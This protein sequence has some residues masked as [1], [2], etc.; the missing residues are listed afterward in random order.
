VWMDTKGNGEFFSHL[1]HCAS[2]QAGERL[3]FNS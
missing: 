2:E 3:N 1:S